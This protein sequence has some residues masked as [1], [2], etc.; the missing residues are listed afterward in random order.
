MNNIEKLI[1]TYRTL[2]ISETLNFAKFNE[3][4]IVHHSAAI[5][6]STLTQT[7]SELLLSDG[8]TPKGKPLT[9]S[10]MVRDHHD[11]LLFVLENAAT[12]AALSLS[13][14]Q[15]VNAIVMKSTGAVRQ[16][17]FG[18]VDERRGEFRK[19]NVSAGGSYFVGFEK[20][21][22][23]TAK[24]IDTVNANFGDALTWTQQ[25]E[26]SFTAHFDLVNIHPFY[27]GNGRTGRLLMN[28]IQ[29]HFDIPLTIVYKEDRADYIQA[30]KDSRAK[31]STAPFTAFMFHQ[32]IK[33]LTSEIEQY[34]N[35]VKIKKGA[36]GRGDSLFF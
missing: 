35:K 17:V 3:Y 16:T 26:L 10:L 11:A 25:V 2:K 13:Y 15:K 30:L 18:E 19:G 14:L 28:H 27:D 4:A 9:H 32:L 20:V 5:E 6:G 33:Q 7:D 23:Y 22:P 21:I 8:I 1:A 36:K 29:R 31:K 34:K 12:R 24:L